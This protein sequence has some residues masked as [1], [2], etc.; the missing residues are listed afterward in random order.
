[1][2]RLDDARADA[3][4]GLA[5][6]RRRAELENVVIG[7]YAMNLWSFMAG[8]PTD[9]LD[10]A[11]EPIQVMEMSTR[12]LHTYAWEGMGMACLLV[13]RPDEAIRALESGPAFVGKGVG[14]FQ[15]ASTLALLSAAYAAAGDAR[16]SFDF[17]T[18][19]VEAARVRGT[20]VY[21]GHALLR[22]AHARRL[23]GQ[24]ESLVAEDLA[25]ARAAIEETG[26]YGYVPF[27]EAAQLRHR[28]ER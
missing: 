8:D 5:E 24:E 10:R 23:L 15:Q 4:S 19:A 1:M 27:L 16:R 20:R 26:A 18:E 7:L 9:A 3:E 25:L 12:Y 14:G 17:A 6:A 21:A 13:G 11:R 2:G 28:T 22:Q